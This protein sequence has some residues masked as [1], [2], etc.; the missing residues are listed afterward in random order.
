MGDYFRNTVYDK[1]FLSDD[2]QIRASAYGKA[3]S[4]LNDGHTMF[5]GS[6]LLGEATGLFGNEYYQTLNK[7]RM[8]LSTILTT[9]RSAE[10]SKTGEDVR[11][12]D[13][14]YSSDGKTAYFSFDDF[15]SR[16]I[17]RTRCPTRTGTR[18][19]ITCSSRI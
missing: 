14:R 6:A 13:V 3:L 11:P 2:P 16:L 8:A 4:L 9:Q 12:V 5:S 7:D 1:E 17:S 15:N 10:L 19:R 18:T